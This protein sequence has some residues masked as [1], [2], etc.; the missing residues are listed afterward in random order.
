[1]NIHL[2]VRIDCISASERLHLY[3]MLVHLQSSAFTL[4]EHKQQYE[5][6]TRN[7]LDLFSLAMN[8]L[9]KM[10]LHIWKF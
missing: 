2:K 8:L 10:R 5:D 9:I 7:Y 3:N 4:E 1:M 6:K